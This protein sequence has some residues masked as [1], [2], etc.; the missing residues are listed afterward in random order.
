MISNITAAA[1]SRKST[2]TALLVILSLMALLL[3][4]A[5]EE[6]ELGSGIRSVYIHVALTWTGMTGLFAAGLIGLGA[7][8]FNR[9]KLQIWAHTIT[10]VA[11]GA[12]IAGLVMS[13]VAA[14][15]NWGGVFW[16]EPR[17]NAVLTVIAAG[18]I[19]QVINSW[20][21]PT[22]LKG[23]LTA[24]LA[25]VLLWMVM[26][27]PLV[28]H[29]GNAARTTPSLAIRFTFFGLYVL[30]LLAASWIVFSV[31]MKEG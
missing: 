21:I 3:L 15:I 17:T 8:L 20:S 2:W 12:F 24:L 18:L 28:L 26:A 6:K 1:T 4:F 9:S 16:Q 14:G 5:P 30:C 19:I 7:A 13:I 25:A 27:T 29:P 22:R 31:R 10:W 11:L 23:F